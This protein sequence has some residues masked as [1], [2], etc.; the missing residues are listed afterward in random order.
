LTPW[1][2]PHNADPAYARARVRHQVLPV[3]ER[4]LG[5]GTAAA[6]ARTSE[7][8]RADADALDGWADS[9]YAACA[10]GKALAVDVLASYPPAVR[11]RVLLRAARDAGCPGT[12]LFAVH[13]TAMD[14]LITDWHGQAGVHL[15][16]GI[17]AARARGWIRFDRTDMAR[18][19]P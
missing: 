5:P 3:L 17:R 6:L 15:P 9:A 19:Q 7:L 8:L 12:D 11:H 10:T 2:D 13:V 4:E 1:D 18:C 16:G 14:A